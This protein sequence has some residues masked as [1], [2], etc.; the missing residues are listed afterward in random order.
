MVDEITLARMLEEARLYVDERKF[1]HAIQVYHH[2]LSENPSLDLAWIELSH[3]YFE[4]RQYEAAER[5]LLNVIGRGEKKDEIYFLIGNLFLKLGQHDRALVYY[6]RLLP[7]DL[8]LSSGFRAHLHFNVGLIYFYKGNFKFAEQHFR[9]AYSLDRKFPKI[10]ESLGEILLR[11]GAVVEAAEHLNAAVKSDP[12]S[13]IAHYMLGVAHT[14]LHRWH[15]AYEEFVTSVE[16]NPT[17]PAGWQMCGEVSIVLQQLDEAEQYLRKALE[18]NP[19]FTDA[20]A[21]FGF[22]FLQRGDP[23]RALEFFEKALALEPRH[24]K[25]LQGRRQLRI[26]HQPPSS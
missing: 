12:Y 19:H 23:K 18:L 7:R 22:L 11:R 10:N 2:I 1:L 9:I 20:V 6:K 5:M 24:P 14:K 4:M 8:T 25:A 21:N 26:G 17:E 13:W 3:V 16:L 15:E